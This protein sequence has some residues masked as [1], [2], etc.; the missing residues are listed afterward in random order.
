MTM[1]RLPGSKFLSG[2]LAPFSIHSNELPV[3]FACRV[4]RPGSCPKQSCRAARYPPAGRIPPLP[5]NPNSQSRWNASAAR[6]HC[7]AGRPVCCHCLLTPRAPQAGPRDARAS[8]SASPV[9]SLWEAGGNRRASVGL[10]R[11]HAGIR[12]STMN[13][14]MVS[15]RRG[16]IEHDTKDKRAAEQDSYHVRHCAIL[17]RC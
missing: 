3:R 17:S 4:S 12:L 6:A 16:C 15:G 10:H 11:Y 14:A 1:I 9:V 13:D 7:R 5:D 8:L 2:G